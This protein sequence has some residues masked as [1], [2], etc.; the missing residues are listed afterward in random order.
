MKKTIENRKLVKMYL[1][2]V[3]PL[4]NSRTWQ[5]WPHGSGFRIKDL[6]KRLWNLPLQLRKATEARHGGSERTLHEAVK[7]KPALS[8]R[9]QV[10]GDGQSLGTCQRTT[11]KE[12]KQPERDKCAAFNRAE[13]S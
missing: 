8:G 7:V 4:T 12:W 2:H 13:R 11:N 10:V 3:P 1:K 9:L 6:R 5:H